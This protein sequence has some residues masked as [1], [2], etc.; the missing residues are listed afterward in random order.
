VIL[1]CV[2]VCYVVSCPQNVCVLCCFPVILK[3][4]CVCVLRRLLSSH[5]Y[6]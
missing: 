1:K 6:V 5:V 3:F 2:C 4:L